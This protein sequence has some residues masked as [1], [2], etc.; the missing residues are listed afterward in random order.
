VES[1]AAAT[2]EVVP[3]RNERRL[4]LVAAAGRGKR[5]VLKDKLN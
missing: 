4:I 3:C 2:N 1:N 5:G